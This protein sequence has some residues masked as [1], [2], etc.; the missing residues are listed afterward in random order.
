MNCI[1]GKT[2]NKWSPPVVP[3]KNIVRSAT[4]KNVRVGQ[5]RDTLLGYFRYGIGCFGDEARKEEEFV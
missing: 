1:Y 3:Q 4:F 2:E 5:S